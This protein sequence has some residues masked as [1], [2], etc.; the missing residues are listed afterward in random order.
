MRGHLDTFIIEIDKYFLYCFS[1]GLVYTRLH[2]FIYAGH[3]LI[4]AFRKLKCLSSLNIRNY[5]YL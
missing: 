1:L 3:T 2:S 4:T 5:Y